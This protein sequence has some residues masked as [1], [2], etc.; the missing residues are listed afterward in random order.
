MN[1]KTSAFHFSCFMLDEHKY[2]TKHNVLP[3]Y[4]YIVSQTRVDIKYLVNCGWI[5][6]E[7]STL[8][9]H[10]I[11]EVCL[12]IG[13]SARKPI[14]ATS[15]PATSVDDCSSRHSQES[16]YPIMQCKRSTD[17]RGS[18]ATVTRTS[19]QSSM[20]HVWNVS[21]PPYRGTV[22]PP[23]HSLHV[24][25]WEASQDAS[26]E[27][28]ASSCV[29]ESHYPIMQCTSHHAMHFRRLSTSY[30][31]GAIHLPSVLPTSL[32]SH[33][34]PS[35]SALPIM[36]CTSRGYRLPMIMAQ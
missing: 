29:E 17:N 34:I 27:C 10:E 3:K 1:K 36:Q 19:V 8:K 12:C 11:Q 15:K 30:E 9:T 22:N 2:R 20:A 18:V 32:K 33:T 26:S 35:C 28:S 25:E 16:H 4:I 23:L 31:D 5:H 14:D 21:E 7:L 13:R 6:C 24:L